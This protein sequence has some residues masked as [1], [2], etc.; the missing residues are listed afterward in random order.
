[1]NLFLSTEFVIKLGCDKVKQVTSKKQ[2]KM[3]AILYK[4]VVPDKTV[5][6]WAVAKR[7][8]GKHVPTNPHPTTEG[9]PL[10]GNRPINTHHSN[11]CA[12]IER[13]FSMGSA[14]RSYL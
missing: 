5:T 9:R 2:D 4:N 3:F 6:D 11:D 1:V 8:I 13:L 7:R 10:L 12:T 14:Q